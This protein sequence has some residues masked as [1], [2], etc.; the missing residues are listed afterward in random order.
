MN[1]TIVWHQEWLSGRDL[2]VRNV[3]YVIL[4]HYIHKLKY[5]FTC[6]K[7]EENALVW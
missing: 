6:L 2:G 7:D 5:N 3:D 1:I 4:D